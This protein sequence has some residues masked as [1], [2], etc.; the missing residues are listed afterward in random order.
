MTKPVS[1]LIIFG[2]LQPLKGAPVVDASKLPLAAAME[3]DFAKEIQPILERSCLKCHG[4]EKA[5][6]K[7]LLD[8]H[9]HALKGGENG[10]DIIPGQSA[11]S[12]LI[13]FTA[14]LVEDSE[15]PP[16]GKG[17]PLTKE[18]VGILRAWIDQGA[19]WPEGLTLRGPEGGDEI[20]NPKSE[21]RN[22]PEAAA[23]QV[24]FVKDIQPI[25]A[26]HCY[27]CHGPKKQQAQFRLDAKEIA[28][29]GGDLGPAIVP[30]KSAE[31]LLIQ[32]VAGVKEDLV[33]PKEGKRLT[34]EQIGLLRAWIDQ[35]AEWP[36]KASVKVEDKRNH[37]AFKAP[38]R[39]AVPA[40]KN[41]KWV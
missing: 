6:G 15:M 14:R 40:V 33:M 5:K 16:V 3:V 8:T 13:H 29:K 41:A 26:G 37:W 18:E 30:E 2:L 1:F 27:E 35:G 38:V 20:R 12:P 10:Q 36:E 9:E 39:P 21:I 17:E 24:D 34:A 32:A 23:R 7:L 22:L 28:L 19:K 31:S 25:F 11:K 4:P